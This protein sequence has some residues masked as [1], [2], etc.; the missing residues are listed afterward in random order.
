MTEN[1]R[2]LKKIKFHNFSGNADV[3]DKMYSILKQLESL[4]SIDLSN[5]SL[6]EQETKA[7]GKVLA[8]FKGIQELNLSNCCLT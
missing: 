1:G 7:V 5:F 6:R 8:A 2:G 3:G 4:K